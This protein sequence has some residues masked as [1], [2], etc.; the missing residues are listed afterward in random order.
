MAGDLTPVQRLP[1]LALGFVAFVVG[2][3]AGL[4]RLGVGV[5][6]VA[7]AASALHGPLMI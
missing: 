7:V 5:P 4:A 1:L 2:T 6:D 3:G